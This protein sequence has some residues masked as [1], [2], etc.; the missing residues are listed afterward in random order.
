MKKQIQ[1]FVL[2]T[3]L[4]CGLLF[5]N[6]NIPAKPQSWVSDYANILTP[7][8]EQ[9]LNSELNGLE[10]RSSNQVFVAVF[11]EIP[12]GEYLED[13]TTKVFEAWRPGLA[14]KNNGILLAIYIRDRKIRMEV[15]YGLEDVITDAQANTLISG[16][17]QPNFRKGNYFQ[18]IKATLDVLIP[19]AEGKYKIPV[20]K[21]SKK[22]KS[23]PFSSIIPIIIVL[24][25]VSRFFRG[26]GSSG[27][28]TRRRGGSILGPMII[29][30]ML[31]G[32]SRGGSFGGGGGF[33]G[34]FGGLSGGGGASGG[35]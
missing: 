12:D 21:K 4:F 27:Y 16:I 19:A 23:S 5:A 35:W 33:G 30:S 29:G 34:G 8:Q 9:Q 20:A 7:A 1:Y 11:Q 25:I 17:L 24:I 2:L 15:G 6:K 14:D 31:G 22:K 32:S 13:Y 3:F 28:G 26:G 10:S 18:G